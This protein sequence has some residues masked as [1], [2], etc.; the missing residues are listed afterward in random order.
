MYN[1]VDLMKNRVIGLL[2]CSMVKQ[3]VSHGS[4][5][6]WEI[7]I[8]LTINDVKAISKIVSIDINLLCFY[9]KLQKKRK[10]IANCNC[11]NAQSASCSRFTS[12]NPSQSYTCIFFYNYLDIFIPINRIKFSK[13]SFVVEHVPINS[14][15]YFIDSKRSKTKPPSQL[16]ERCLLYSPLDRC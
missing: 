10:R 3:D 1:Y 15:R 14:I 4:D 2:H 9:F 6:P 12:S 5:N 8:G 7:G 16:S 13:C 11:K